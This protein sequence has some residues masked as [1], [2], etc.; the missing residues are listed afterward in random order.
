MHSVIRTEYNRISP[1]RYYSGHI[2]D[3]HPPFALCLAQAILKHGT[4]A[5]FITASLGLIIELLIETRLLSCKIRRQYRK[6]LVSVTL[7][8]VPNHRS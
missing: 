4:D 1:S 6:V 8:H 5:M 3:P 2:L 7:L